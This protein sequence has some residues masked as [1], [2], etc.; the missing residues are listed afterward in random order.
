MKE[1]KGILS[2]IKEEERLAATPMTEEGLK[3]A[4]SDIFSE[5]SN[6][7]DL[8]KVMREYEKPR[9]DEEIIRAFLTYAVPEGVYKI[10]NS[11]FIAWTGKG[12]YIEHIIVKRRLEDKPKL[13]R[14]RK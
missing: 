13:L 8:V 5:S 3:E 12:G 2:Q 7:D 14:F 6:F 9:E 1:G 10:G 11:N 4:I